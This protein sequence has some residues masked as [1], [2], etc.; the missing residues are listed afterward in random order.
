M[1]WARRVGLVA[2]IMGSLML[3]F[4][5][6]ARMNLVD[7]ALP[8]VPHVDEGIWTRRAIKILKTG[9]LNPHR[10]TKPSLMVYLNTA[11]FAVGMLRSG[12]GAGQIPKLEDIREGGPYY[13][14]VP[15]IRTVR[16]VYV[17]ISIAAM[18]LGALIARHLS[19]EIALASSGPSV[20]TKPKEPPWIQS[21][22]ATGII[23]LGAMLGS[24]QYL[25]YSHWYL[26]VDLLGC[27]AIL[28]TIAYL[29]FARPATPPVVFALVAGCLGGLCIGTKYNLYPIVVP[30]LL[31]I[32]FRHKDRIVS[33][34]VLYFLSLLAV[35]FITTPYAIF[36]LPEFVSG[37]AGEAAHY[38]RGRDGHAITPGFLSA[39]FYGQSAYR[40]LG[41]A[42]VIVGLIGVG[43]ALRHAMKAAVLV[44]SFP[45]LFWAYMSSQHTFFARN[46][47]VLSLIA[48]I[49]FALGAPP[50][51]RW[52]GAL[53]AKRFARLASRS[54]LVGLLVGLVLFAGG[55][56]WHSLWTAYMGPPESRNAAVSWL[57][58]NAERGDLFVAQQLNVDPRSY[59][60]GFKVRV[61]DAN[62]EGLE[63][64]ARRH[65]G[66]FAIAPR[67]K[68]GSPPLSA[69]MLGRWGGG[70]RSAP[71][72]RGT[73]WQT[74][75]VGGGP[76]LVLVRF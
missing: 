46:M 70:N 37:V 43:L 50:A 62:E 14:S 11:S 29:L 1:G 7:Q 25:R 6:R 71:S 18:A 66:A 75:V 9:D 60:E 54:E 45:L 55:L 38:T 32:F 10:F 24:A 49:F 41:I 3:A 76:E 15:M 44:L 63:V 48:P 39:A 61:Y 53:V 17:L 68:K 69:D 23:A 56:R 35:F 19:R 73:R 57:K 58:L 31:A 22:D 4:G 72:P 26:C 8:Y 30:S 64:L 65:P 5:Y 12:M 51:V 59:P 42:G 28:A 67:P 16:Q 13:T 33:S 74:D 34:G 47:L 27:L 20:A 2:L 52:L 36:A 21:H 40:D